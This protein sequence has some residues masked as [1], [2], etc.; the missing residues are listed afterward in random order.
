M[1]DANFAF[2]EPRLNYKENILGCMRAQHAVPF[3]CA[4]LAVS[5]P[6]PLAT[7]HGWQ[8][9]APPPTYFRGPPRHKQRSGTTDGRTDG[10]IETGGRLWRAGLSMLQDRRY[11]LSI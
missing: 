6:P 11:E 4:R 10:R 2:Y 7:T 8:S 3:A 1:L 9:R 5:V